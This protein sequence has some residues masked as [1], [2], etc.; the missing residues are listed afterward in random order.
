MTRA[1]PTGIPDCVII[2]ETA[3]QPR[4]SSPQ[5]TCRGVG[6]VSA[7]DMPGNI[8]TSVST[9]YDMADDQNVRF[10]D[11]SALTC[12]AAPCWPPSKP[13]EDLCHDT[14]S[15]GCDECFG[16]I[17]ITKRAIQ[18]EKGNAEGKKTEKRAEAFFSVGISENPSRSRPTSAPARSRGS[19]A[20]HLVDWSPADHTTSLRYGEPRFVRPNSAPGC[21]P[22]GLQASQ[23]RLRETHAA[24]LDRKRSSFA[25]LASGRQ[26]QLGSA[27]EGDGGKEGI[28]S[29]NSHD[30]AWWDV[31]QANGD[32]R[33]CSNPGARGE[34]HANHQNAFDDTGSRIILMNPISHAEKLATPISTD[35]EIPR[36]ADDE[37]M[38]LEHS[39]EFRRI[40]LQL[41]VSV[42]AEGLLLAPESSTKY[43]SFLG[44]VK[45]VD[46]LRSPPRSVFI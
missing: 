14:S 22:G 9:D 19:Q 10:G 4:F 45:A 43:R 5:G 11:D 46:T 39:R 7:M 27:N 17:S 6:N 12:A 38:D 23:R 3:N 16:N 13:D 31:H 44:R 18:D 36:V 25:A 21:I 8:L 24:K 20:Q 30:S 29:N 28:G 32:A 34:P 41:K 33:K 40:A 35:G 15:S 37:D 2:G 1:F 42:T 26:G